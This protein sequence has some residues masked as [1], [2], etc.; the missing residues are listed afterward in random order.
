MTPDEFLGNQDASV[1]LRTQLLEP[2]PEG[3]LPTVVIQGTRA[4]LRFLAELLT[5]IAAVGGLPFDI[6]LDP[7]GAG[8]FHFDETSS[9]GLYIECID[10]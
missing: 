2:D 10:S 7:R 6:H 8:E 1:R 9:V 3:G 5:K 4:A